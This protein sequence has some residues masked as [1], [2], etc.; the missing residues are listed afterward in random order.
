METIL[1]LNTTDTVSGTLYSTEAIEKML[2]ECKDR[3]IYVT[4][5][6]GSGFDVPFDRI[7][8]NVTKLFIEDS[9]LKIDYM[10]YDTSAAHILKGLQEE[11]VSVGFYPAMTANVID[12][13]AKDIKLIHVHVDSEPAGT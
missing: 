3:S 1:K 4:L 11:K 6:V 8:G 5:G 13:E 12:K 9:E 2:D 7:I 10:L